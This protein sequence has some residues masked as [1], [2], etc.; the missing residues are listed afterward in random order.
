[1]IAALLLATAPTLTPQEAQTLPVPELA[2]RVLGAA[3]AIVV[4]VERPHFPVCVGLCPPL[5]PHSDSPPPLTSLTLYTRASAS[6]EADWLGLCRATAI[7]V[8]FDKSGIVTSLDQRTTVGWLGALTRTKT[9]NGPGGAAAVS[10]QY[11]DFEAR[12]RA[13]PTTRQFVS[14][15]GPPRWRT[16]FHR[17]VACAQQHGEGRANPR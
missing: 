4:D 3:G 8:N 10:S 9:G 17:G 6:S 15:F 2:A 5:L 11:A 7:E 13:L 14:A 12:C 16:S 1:M